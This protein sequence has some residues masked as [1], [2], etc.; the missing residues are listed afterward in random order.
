MLREGKVLVGQGDVTTD[1]DEFRNEGFVQGDA[2]GVVFQH[3]VT[4]IGNYGGTVAFH[5][6][7][8]PG[9]GP[10]LIE[11][12]NATF[13]TTNTLTIQIGGLD[14]GTE[15]AS[16][17]LSGMANLGGSL[18]GTLLD[19]G[20]GT[21]V[22]T[23]GD[24]FEIIAAAGGINDTFDGDVSL[25]PLTGD[26]SWNVVYGTN[27]VALEILTPYTADFDGNGMVDGNDLGFWQDAMILHAH[28]E[29]DADSDG[30]TDGSDFLAWQLQVGSGLGVPAA[31]VPEPSSLV[32]LSLGMLM[33]FC[34]LNLE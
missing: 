5:G 26:L 23:A 7:Y 30:D 16:L 8:T 1:N 11:L 14:K 27:G 32:L 20:G 6:G 28:D 3:L 24:T 25:P 10:T 2:P 31:A 22:P 21:F 18:N 15:Y 34:R 29:A 13:G 17:E 12:E 33:L 19:L 4:G 9:N